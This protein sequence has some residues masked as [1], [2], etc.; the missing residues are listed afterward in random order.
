MAVKRRRLTDTNVAR[1]SPAAREYT[2]WDKRQA[3]LGA[4][5]RPSGHRSFVYWRKGED[6]AR[7]ITLGSAALMSVEEARRQCLA[8][9]SGARSG[10]TQ[11]S[12]VPTFGEFVEGPGRSC[13]ERGKPSTR[14]V[15]ARIV[16]LHLLP[17]FGSL[18]VV[19]CSR[20]IEVQVFCSH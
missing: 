14:K 2:V 6:G 9:E 20:S 1:L 12:E 13:F 18:R 3:G 4:R 16:S 8:I 17:A 11:R 19:S 10:R 7:R 5:V 15:T